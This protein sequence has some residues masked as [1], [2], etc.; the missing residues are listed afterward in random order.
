MVIF[1]ANRANLQ[2]RRLHEGIKKRWEGYLSQVR[3]IR[4]SARDPGMYRVVGEVDPRSFLDDESYPARETRI[5]IGFKLQTPD[6]YEH[7][8]FDWIEPERE[9]LVGWHQDDDHNGLGP[10]HLQVND[11]TSA[12]DHQPAHFVDDHPYSVVEQRFEELSAVIAAIEWDDSG[13]PSGF[14]VS[15]PVIDTT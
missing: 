10:V 3:V 11:G 9:L 7:Y 1:F 2:V 13:R 15:S 6:P 5:E 14:D 8:W 4:A 12:V